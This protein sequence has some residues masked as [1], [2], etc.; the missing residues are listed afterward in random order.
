LIK[1]TYTLGALSGCLWGGLAYLLGH[2][3]MGSIIWGG[4][5]V[6]P[7]IGI[8]MAHV[9]RHAYK[10]RLWGRV[11]F[12]LL[13][14]YWGAILFGLATGLADVCRGNP[15]SIPHALIL[16]SVL[17]TLWGVTFTGYIVVLWPLSFLNHWLIHKIKGAS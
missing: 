3:W 17:A 10:F 2:A 14:L 15:N 11:F 16:H 4:V 13:T 7:G 9:S 1:N 5:A 6:S 12:A 8:I